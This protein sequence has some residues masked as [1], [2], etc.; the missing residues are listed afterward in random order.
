MP[1][2]QEEEAKK[3]G[4][5]KKKKRLAW[6]QTEMSSLYG[7]SEKQ[8]HWPSKEVC[9]PLTPVSLQACGELLLVTR[10]TAASL[11]TLQNK[12]ETKSS[13]VGREKIDSIC[14]HGQ[15]GDVV[16]WI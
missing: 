14:I 6:P 10:G 12:P 4:V 8:R 3:E 5:I 9:A 2:A 13:F 1:L 7:D 16:I 15:H 11:N